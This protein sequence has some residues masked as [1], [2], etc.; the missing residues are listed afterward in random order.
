MM[1]EEIFPYKLFWHQSQGSMLLA[2][3]GPARS[4]SYQALLEL[5]YRVQVAA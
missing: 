2:D 3:P 1:R 4:N 5:L